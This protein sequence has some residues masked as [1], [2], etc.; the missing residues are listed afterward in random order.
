MRGQATDLLACWITA[1]LAMLGSSQLAVADPGSDWKAGAA[2]VVISP[3]APVPMAGAASNKPTDGK[4]HDLYAKAL[5]LE[6]H[7]GT[8]LVI[9]TVDVCMIPMDVRK[10][11]EQEVRQ[12]FDLPP[13]SLLLN[14]SHTHAGPETRARRAVLYGFSPAEIKQ[15]E[16][17]VAWLQQRLVKVIG[18]ALADLA[19]ASLSYCK[20]QAG[21]AVNRRLKTGGGYRMAP[22]PDG[23]VDHEVPVLVVRRPDGKPRAVLF[24]YACHAVAFASRTLCG[25]FPGFTQRAV[26]KKYP[27]AVAMF[28][29]GCGGDQTPNQRGSAEAAENCG[30]QLADAVVRAIN[31]DQAPLDSPLRL[32][33]ETVAIEFDTPPTREQLVQQA[34]ALQGIPQRRAKLL[35]EKLDQTGELSRTYPYH[36]HVIRFGDD[37][38][39]V[40][41]AWE[42]V[43]DYSLRLKKEL[44][45]P[46]VWVAGYSNEMFNY[47]PSLRVLREGGYEAGGSLLGYTSAPAPLA[48]SVEKL[49]VGKAKELAERTKEQ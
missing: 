14:A 49:V 23:V 45:G 18:E 26:E 15:V 41:L 44:A 46:K 2:A 9:V 29:T 32:A 22:N 36:V 47:L 20:D 48:P 24:G 21:F 3:P 43:V 4:I 33:L 30:L 7:R 38:I 10:A 34:K 40:G 12:R 1:S 27:G 39:L 19:P 31:A 6:D 11:M 17:Y 5:A 25:D 8:R 35:L 28:L 37:M 16:D 42:V 13:Q